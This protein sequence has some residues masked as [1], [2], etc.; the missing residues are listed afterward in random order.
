MP[1]T[2]RIP[3]ALCTIVMSVTLLAQ[4]QQPAGGNAAMQERVA[5][6]KQALAA[7]QAALKQYTWTETTEISLKGEV[8]KREQ[9]SCRYGADGK[10][11]KTPISGEETPQS[12]Q[13][14]DSRGGRRRGAQ[15]AKK[16]V[17]AHKVGAI[18]D[19]MEQVVA[20]V[21]EYVPPDKDK[22]QAAASAGHVSMQPNP[23]SGMA[24][25]SIQDYFKPGDS[26]TV[27]LDVK[28]NALTTYDVRSYVDDPKED[29]VT[30][31]VRFDRLP[32][33]TSYPQQT[34]VDAVAKQIQVKV[35]NSGYAKG[36]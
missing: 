20:L 13:Q 10:V 31:A 34:V 16:A 25:L 3:I 4:G 8:K 5:A 7:N 33:G 23:A 22:I 2:M 17:V 9:K 1:L 26:L 30:L 29:V 28:A 6:L 32:D 35:T 14:E 19:Y 36:Q 21:H 18:K 11:Q 12:S 24:A 15:V 27:G